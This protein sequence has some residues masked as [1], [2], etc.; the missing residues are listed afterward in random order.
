LEENNQKLAAQNDTLR[1]LNKRLNT[2]LEES[3]RQNNES[4]VNYCSRLNFI[5]Q[6]NSIK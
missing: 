1:N 6:Q 2:Q 3:E 5:D 4:N